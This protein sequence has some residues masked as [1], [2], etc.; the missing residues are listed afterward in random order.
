MRSLVEAIDRLIEANNA[1]RKRRALA[2]PERR[3]ALAMARAFRAEERAFL[4]RLKEYS[5]RFPSESLREIAEPIDWEGPF[6]KAALATLNA[7]ARPLDEFTARAL[8]AGMISGVADLAVETS[9]TL[10][11]LA[12]VEYLKTHGSNAVPD[13]RETTRRRLRPLLVQAAEEGWSYNR[14]AKEI[15]SLYKSMAGPPR[16]TYSPR[17]RSRAHEI[18]VYVLGDAYEHGNMLVAKDLQASGLE[19]VKKWQSVGDSRVRPA[20][21][22]NQ[23][24]GWISLDASFQ[25]GS[26]RPPS[27][28]GCRCTTLLRR[29][30][31]A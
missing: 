23:A 18:A 20:H 9:F 26:D 27:D 13:L 21:R 16:L 31:D 30:P 19:M 14:T 29:K 17:I 3:L 28:S 2:K 1:L 8:A 6:D 25:D 4:S 10:E 12:A 11:H 24:Q 7:F 5:G 15:T 22:A